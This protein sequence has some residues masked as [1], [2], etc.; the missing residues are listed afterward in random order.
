[1]YR[2]LETADMLHSRTVCLH[3]LHV[4][5]EDGKDL[6]VKDL[7]LSDTVGHLLQ[8]LRVLNITDYHI[9]HR[10][11]DALHTWFLHALY[12]EILGFKHLNYNQN[13]IIKQHC[14]K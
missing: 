2:R 13:T 9:K 8:W 10:T 5:V 12:T 4:L 1:M 3:G 7:I 6:V 11:T 14:T